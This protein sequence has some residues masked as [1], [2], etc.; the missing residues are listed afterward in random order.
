L[1]PPD[2][3]A[4]LTLADPAHEL[5]MP[6]EEGRRGDEEG[7]PAVAPQDSARGRGQDPVDG[8]E[9]RSARRPLQHLELMAEDEDLQV[10]GSVSVTCGSSDDEET[11]KGSGDEVEE[12]E[13]RPIVPG[14]SESESGFPTP[15]GMEPGCVQPRQVASKRL[16]SAGA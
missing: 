13:H 2:Q 5:A 8:P 15:T 3:A 4:R 10:L 9:P 6:P 14:R 1:L 7:H 11:S 16:V 12:G